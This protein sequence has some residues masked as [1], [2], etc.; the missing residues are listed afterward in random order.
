[1]VVSTRRIYGVD[2]CGDQQGLS[3]DLV[4]VSRL[5]LMEYRSI[6]VLDFVSW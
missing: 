1:M 3:L 4:L 2:Q 5:L 6:E